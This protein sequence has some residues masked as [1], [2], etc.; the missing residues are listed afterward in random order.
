[1]SSPTPILVTI[2]S[3]VYGITGVEFPTFP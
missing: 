2:V 3:G 1:M